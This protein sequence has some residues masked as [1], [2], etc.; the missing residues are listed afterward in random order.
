MNQ[1]ED[2]QLLVISVDEVRLFFSLS[3]LGR[4]C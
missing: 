2:Q 4:K 1:N 3:F